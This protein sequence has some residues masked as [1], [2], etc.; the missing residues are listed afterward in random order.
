LEPINAVSAR[1]T[2][3]TDTG[4]ALHDLDEAEE[5]D[6][7]TRRRSWRRGG[8]AAC[9]SRRPAYRR[10]HAHSNPSSDTS[11]VPVPA[12]A[13]ECGDGIAVGA[14]PGTVDAYVDFLCPFC[15]QFEYRA[16]DALTRL[17][18]DEIITL[19]HHPLGFLDGLTVPGGYSTR[20]SAASACASDAG[21]FPEY[22]DALFANQ[23]AEG[24]PGQ[25]DEELVELGRSVGIDDQR[26][27]DGVFA[28]TYQ[29]W[30]RFVTEIAIERGIGGT[31]TVLVASIPVPAPP[32]DPRRRRRGRA[33]NGRCLRQPR[34]AP[35]GPAPQAS[36]A[37]MT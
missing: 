12:G 32:D 34:R 31:P 10:S 29:P 20:A 35:R 7:V 11:S 1:R 28:G 15:K 30:T 33:L 21:R 17:V 22:E 18:H 3:G 8:G 37:T 36:A 23:P 27:A 25:D 9:T 26:F 6:G 19:V 2:A 14:G 24:G 16:R 4:P 13:T 5:L